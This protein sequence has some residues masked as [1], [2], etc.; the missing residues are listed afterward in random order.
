MYNR[1]HSSGG[2]PIPL[3]EPGTP[4]T[5]GK[6]RMIDPTVFIARGAIVLGDVQ[7]GK[8]ASVWYNAVIRGDVERI[9]IGEATNIQDL[10]DGPRRPG[11][12]VRRGEPGHGGPPG[13]FA[14]L[15]RRGRL[16]DRHGGDLAQSASVSAKARSS[17]REPSCSKGPRCRQGRWS[18][19]FRAASYVRS[20][21]S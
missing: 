8:D 7:I 19:A 9:S 17:G 10:I 20:T 4:I 14:R 2:P 12:P 11:L 16:L 5:L 1:A 15:H 6:P 13:H 21:R 3:D 18:L